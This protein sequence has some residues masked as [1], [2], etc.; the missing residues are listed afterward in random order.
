M[1]FSQYC[2]KARKNS[3][4][5]GVLPEFITVLIGNRITYRNSLPA[6]KK[7]EFDNF[8]TSLSSGNYHV[9]NFTYTDGK[10]YAIFR[11]WTL[12]TSKPKPFIITIVR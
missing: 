2:K 1:T 7:T 4:L 8:L 12:S 9:A 11:N 10:K 3:Q 5:S 6:W